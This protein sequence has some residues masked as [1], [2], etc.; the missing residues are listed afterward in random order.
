MRVLESNNHI[1]TGL[2][3][4]FA[5]VSTRSDWTTIQIKYHVMARLK[6]PGAKG[7]SGERNC[8]VSPKCLLSVFSFFLFSF[9]PPSKFLL[10]LPVSRSSSL[11]FFLYL[12]LR[13]GSK[14]L[15][16]HP[17]GPAELNQQKT[18]IRRNKTNRNLYR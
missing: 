2:K 3:T 15:P 9:F 14:S 8:F 4:N 10:F 18:R 12:C 16:W 5:R 11:S 1:Y 17:Q 6:L 7:R 13:Y